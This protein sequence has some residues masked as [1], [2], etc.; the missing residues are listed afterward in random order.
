MFTVLTCRGG[1]LILWNV[2]F[3]AA[4]TPDKL[5][6]IS[7]V[8]SPT[9]GNFSGKL[10]ESDNTSSAKIFGLNKFSSIVNSRRK[11]FKSK[12]LT[13]DLIFNLFIYFFHNIS[14]KILIINIF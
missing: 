6:S 11:A 4:S 13:A 14:Y 5:I 12:S 9:I 2:S 3:S 10:Y 8:S 7:N 1:G